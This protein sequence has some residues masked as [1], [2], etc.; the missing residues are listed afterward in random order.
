MVFSSDLL[1]LV[2]GG[3]KEKKAITESGS[4]RLVTTNKQLNT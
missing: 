2:D 4:N 3:L 1:K